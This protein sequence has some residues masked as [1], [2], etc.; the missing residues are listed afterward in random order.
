MSEGFNMSNIENISEIKRLGWSHT[1]SPV[2]R[3][4]SF[5]TSIM[6]DPN[7][8]ES[9]LIKRPV[10]TADNCGL[11]EDGQKIVNE[12]IGT[13]G[14]RILWASAHG[15][16]VQIVSIFKWDDG[17]HESIMQLL[18]QTLFNGQATIVQGTAE[19]SKGWFIGSS[20]TEVLDIQGPP[21]SLQAKNQLSTEK[22]YTVCHW[23][24]SFVRFDE[25]EKVTEYQ[26]FDRPLSVKLIPNRV[27][28]AA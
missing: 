12:I 27:G 8:E 19:D 3:S 17:F 10:T 25:N 18:N 26:T 15:I 23:G 14:T 6:V 24:R 1:D 7:D 9:I 2:T 21:T 13:E 4:Y 22:K 5:S 11:T 28:S 20:L 16:N